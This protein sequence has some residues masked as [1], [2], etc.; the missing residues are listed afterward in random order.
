[1]QKATASITTLSLLGIVAIFGV[2]GRAQTILH[3]PKIPTPTS[4]NVAF[5]GNLAPIIGPSP[6]VNDPHPSD[7]M[8]DN[9][10]VIPYVPGVECAL[11]TTPPPPPMHA[12][13]HFALGAYLSTLGPGMEAALP[14]ANHW[15]VRAG[16][17]LFSYSTE[18]TQSGIA[19]GAN[20]TLRSVQASLDWF[21]HGK[22]FHISPGVLLYNGIR[23]NTNLLIPVNTSFSLNN[24]TYYSDPLDPLT[25]SA[26]IGFPLAGPQLT[27]GFGNMLPR[28]ERQHFSVPF[29]F[30]VAY[31]GT[32]NAVLQFAGSACTSL[33]GINCLPVNSFP[34]FQSDVT[35]EESLIQKD[36]GYARFFPILHLGISYKF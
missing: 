6:A 25:G 12:F 33:G 31:F 4:S 13:S 14:L 5:A 35:A 17:N 32:G 23:L 3:A 19:Y 16:I 2:I 28:K 15:N 34:R 1:M 9:L 18:M 27:A 21:P 7:M 36:L 24:V 10:T 22:G 8:S 26:K 20:F 29:E 30:G 11:R